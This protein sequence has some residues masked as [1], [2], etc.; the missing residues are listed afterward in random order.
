MQR[1]NFGRFS[2]AASFAMLLGVAACSTVPTPSF[3]TEAAPEADLAEYRTYAWAFTGSATGAVNTPIGGRVKTA[4]DESLRSYGFREVPID[5]ADMILAFTIGARD[6]VDVRDW[7]P[8][9]PFYPAYGRAYRYGWSYSY[10]DVDVR[11]VTDGSLALDVF[12]GKT[13][14]PVWHGIATEPLPSGDASNELI[15]L[16][17]SGLVERFND[18]RSGN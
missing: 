8:V 16:A 1:S 9:A 5:D 17:A 6:R 15:R 7:G 3:K 4:L 10:N 2:I 14:R 11:T 13:N 12:D 18:D